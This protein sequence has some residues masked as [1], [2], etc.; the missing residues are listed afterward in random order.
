MSKDPN[1]SDSSIIG[2]IVG[3]NRYQPDP[4]YADEALK[5]S[6]RTLANTV[7][8][9]A[10]GLPIVLLLGTLIGACFHR[11]ISAFYY[12]GFLGGVYVAS[13]WTIGVLLFA[14]KGKGPGE[15]WVATLGGALAIGTAIIPTKGDACLGESHVGRVFAQIENGPTGATVTARPAPPGAEIDTYFFLTEHAPII[16]LICAAGFLLFLAYYSFFVFTRTIDNVNKIEQVLTPVKATRNRTYRICGRIIFFCVL[17]IGAYF[18]YENENRSWEFW[19]KARLTF[20]FETIAV[21]AFGVSWLVK[22]RIFGTSLFDVLPSN[23]TN[24]AS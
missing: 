16:H 8:I 18:I 6:Q 21:W 11:S 10:I 23:A 24:A 20:V 14:Y 12:S 9:I 19:Q 17:I 22:G 3:K 1:Q 4:E 15:A 13:V 7:A 5:A 2:A